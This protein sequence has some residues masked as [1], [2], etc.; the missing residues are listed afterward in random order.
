MNNGKKEFS[1]LSRRILG[2]K[3]Q[4]FSTQ[5][6]QSLRGSE[7]QTKVLVVKLY[8]SPKGVVKYVQ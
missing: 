6:I 2:T 4:Y 1:D 7:N 3:I 8:F 5:T